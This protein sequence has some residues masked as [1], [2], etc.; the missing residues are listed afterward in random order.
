MFENGTQWQARVV[1]RGGQY[2][3]LPILGWGGLKISGFKRSEMVFL[4]I[5]WVNYC[6]ITGKYD[7]KNTITI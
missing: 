3:N 7:F 1:E 2:T 5:W 6:N 4:A